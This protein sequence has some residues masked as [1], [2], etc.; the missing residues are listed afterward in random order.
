MNEEERS[1]LELL[2]KSIEEYYPFDALYADMAS[3]ET[4]KV[5]QDE[6]YEYLKSLAH[7]LLQSVGAVSGA[8]Q[9]IIEQLI[10]LDPFC[11]YPDITNRIK[12]ELIRGQ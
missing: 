6:T 5:E 4:V 9:R 12:E 7:L 3:D 10:I 8:K 1:S 2:L 11:N